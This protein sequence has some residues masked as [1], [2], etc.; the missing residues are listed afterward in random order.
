MILQEQI[1]KLSSCSQEIKT[2]IQDAIEPLA[3][4]DSEFIN[5]DDKIDGFTEFT[6]RLLSSKISWKGNWSFY[7]QPDGVCLYRLKRDENF[8]NV[9]MSF[10]ILINSEMLVSMY[11]NESEAD[12]KELN[13][14]L[15]NSRLELWSQFYK[16]SEYYQ[17]EPKLQVQSREPIIYINRALENLE[18]VDGAVIDQ[19]IEPI[20]SQLIMIAT[21]MDKMSKYS[22]E[23]NSFEVNLYPELKYSIELSEDSRELK[24]EMLETSK[25][26]GKRRRTNGNAPKRRFNDDIFKC[27]RC[28]NFFVT[29]EEFRKHQQSHVR[30]ISSHFEYLYELL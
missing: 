28:D 20:K 17:T 1:K 6:D 8:K 30:R 29:A 11:Q 5:E 22:V 13:W 7:E 24:N 15:K 16:L 19:L 27:S 4:V 18:N 12:I 10:K 14:I 21:D 25:R 23:K 9:S 3:F 2:E 26:S